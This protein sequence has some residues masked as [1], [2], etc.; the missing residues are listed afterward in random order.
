ME[1]LAQ[2]FAVSGVLIF[3]TGLTCLYI[4]CSEPEFHYLYLLQF[5]VL[6]PVFLVRHWQAAKQQG[7]LIIAGLIL[8]FF[9]YGHGW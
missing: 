2:F 8:T 1:L 6:F 5:F 9:G 7:Y 3:S 4:K